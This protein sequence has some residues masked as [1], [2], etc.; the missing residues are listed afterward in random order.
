MPRLVNA[1]S[2]KQMNA[3]SSCV[4]R[5]KLICAA[6]KM[7]RGAIRLRKYDANEPQKFYDGIKD[8][9]GPIRGSVATLRSTNCSIVIK[10]RHGILNRLVDT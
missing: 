4:Q 3:S 5:P 9:Y 2:A 8:V 7:T 1:V 10:D 6:W